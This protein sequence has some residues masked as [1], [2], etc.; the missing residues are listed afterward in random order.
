MTLVVDPG[1]YK[2]TDFV[3]LGTPLLILTYLVT[4]VMAPLVFPFYPS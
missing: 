4:L 1:S 2:F 3:K